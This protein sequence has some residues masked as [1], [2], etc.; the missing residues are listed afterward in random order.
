MLISYKIGSHHSILYRAPAKSP[1]CCELV[2]FGLCI[3][4]G[5]RTCEKVYGRAICGS[6]GQTQPAR[7]CLPSNGKLQAAQKWSGGRGAKVWMAKRCV[8]KFAPRTQSKTTRLQSDT[9]VPRRLCLCSLAIASTF[10][11][12]REC[13]ALRG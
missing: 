5:A 11:C 2:S 8:C 7:T 3:P 4:L 13:C 10:G 12:L 6:S 9:R 1:K